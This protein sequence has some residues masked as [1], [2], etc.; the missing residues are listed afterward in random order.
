MAERLIEIAA[1]E[2]AEHGPEIRGLAEPGEA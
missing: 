2:H 1:L